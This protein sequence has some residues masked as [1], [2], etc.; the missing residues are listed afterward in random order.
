[1]KL[2]SLKKSFVPLPV[3]TYNLY[4]LAEEKLQRKKKMFRKQRCLLSAP[5]TPENIGESE[6]EGPTIPN[7][8][9]SE[10]MSSA[11]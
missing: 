8:P 11:L 2:V 10:L 1:M 5:T 4:L 6:A 7:Y 9:I 3:S